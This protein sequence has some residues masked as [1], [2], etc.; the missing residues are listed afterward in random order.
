LTLNIR[1]W[2]NLALGLLAIGLLAFYVVGKQWQ[3][4]GSLED[5]DWPNAMITLEPNGAVTATWLGTTTILF[6]DGETQVLIDG[7]FTRVHP[8]S[9]I[10]SLPVKSDIANINFA[11][12]TFRINRLAAI[13]PVHSHFDHAMDIGHIANRTSAVVLGSESTANIARGEDVPVDQY[14]ILADGESRQF[15][16]FTITLITSHHAPTS[17]GDEEYFPGVIKRPVRQPARASEWKTGV[18]WSIIIGHPRGNTL[19]QGS[20]GF[21]QDKL[22]DES[23]D[24]VML[25]IAKLAGLGKDYVDSLWLETVVATDAARVI[26]IHHDDYTQ[27]FGEVKLLPNMLDNIKKTTVWL[28]EI[29]T[30]TVPTT[31]LELPPFGQPMI[32]Y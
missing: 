20:G 28:E 16:D 6:D 10:L 8:I 24:V 1:W 22:A 11:L 26:A 5:I 27:P 23:V 17:A 14:Q 7:T 21:I 19:V 12:S 15:G 29:R 13:V 30:S 9:V 31:T 25:S 3:I 18:T 32:L 2:R 4:R